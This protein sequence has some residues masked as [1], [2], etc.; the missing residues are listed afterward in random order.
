MATQRVCRMLEQGAELG[1]VERAPTMI[2]A[3]VSPA[4]QGRMRFQYEW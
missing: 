2:K 3:P 4:F 1:N